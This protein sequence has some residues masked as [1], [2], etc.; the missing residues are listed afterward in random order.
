MISTARIWSNPLTPGDITALFEESDDPTDPTDPGEDPQPVPDEQLQGA[1]TL[2]AS[3]SDVIGGEEVVITVGLAHA[4]EV[5]RVWLHSTPQLLGTFTVSDV[6]TV[7]VTLPT[8]LSAGA[9][10]LVVQATDGSL[11]GWAAL[12]VAALP[13]TGSELTGP[14]RSPAALRSCCCSSAASPSSR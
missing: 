9:H 6:G 2:S 3:P 14:P 4:G 7:T 10:R 13:T 12:N 1:P 11:I 5:V 8:A